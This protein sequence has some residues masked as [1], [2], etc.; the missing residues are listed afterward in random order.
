MMPPRTETPGVSRRG[1]SASGEKPPLREG[2]SDEIADYTKL[3][4]KWQTFVQRE[5]SRLLWVFYALNGAVVLMVGVLAYEDYSLVTRQPQE[6]HYQ[7]LITDKVIMTL[8]SASAA[9]LGLLA[10]SAGKQLLLIPDKTLSFIGSTRRR[11]AGSDT[12]PPTKLD[13]EE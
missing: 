12:G 13:R 1:E 7:R 5:L 9:Q 2:G 10:V 8:I 6:V 4:D 11:I 3:L